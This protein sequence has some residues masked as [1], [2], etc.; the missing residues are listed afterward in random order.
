MATT[1]IHSPGRAKIEQDTLRTDRWWIQPLG[2]FLALSA[3]V[4]Y[5]A[6]RV[7]SGKYYYH[8]PY[9]S[10]FY[11][12]CL[13][14]QCV[15]GAEPGGPISWWMLSPS[16][17]IAWIPLTFRFTCYY[18]RKA[19]FRSFW[20]SPPACAV[21]EPHSAYSGERKLPLI[22]NNL[23]RY[24]LYLALILNVV[25][26]IDAVLAFKT[27]G[28]KWGYLGL[29]T[30]ILTANAVALWLYTLSCHSCRNITAG[31]ITHFSKHPLRYKAWTFVSKINEHHMLYAWISL[32]TVVL[33]DFYVYLLASGRISDLVFFSA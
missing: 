6:W 2:V 28:G 17:L 11:S 9:I 29:G 32:C 30:L 24:A 19:Y 1:G 7:F 12:P 5:S 33:A 18:Y 22:L 13:T 3:F 10:L 8:A 14:T 4:A 23:H 16:L 21:A 20:L 27:P 31:R 26:T 25:L 15:E